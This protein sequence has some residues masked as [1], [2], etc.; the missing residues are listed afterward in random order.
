[1]MT[2]VWGRI[3][4]QGQSP[5]RGLSPD[6]RAARVRY[7]EAMWNP[8]RERIPS[9]LD[10]TDQSLIP[11][12]SFLAPSLITFQLRS[13]DF[14]YNILPRISLYIPP[15]AFPAGSTIQVQVIRL[16]NH[17]DYIFADL[18]FHSGEIFYESVGRS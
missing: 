7:Q 9:T 11:Y 15:G 13:S 2:G 5:E 14:V 6:E 8:G 18:P 12:P 16:Q 17:A 3:P 10:N 4:F 1:M